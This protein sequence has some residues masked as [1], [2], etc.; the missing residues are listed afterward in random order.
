MAEEAYNSKG[1]PKKPNDDSINFQ[2]LLFLCAKNWYWFLISLLIALSL[3][4]MYIMI[5]QPVYTRQASLLIRE[6]DKN[7][8]ISKEFSQFS[9]MGV[10][11]SRTNLHNEMITLKS[12]TYMIDVV[13]KLHLDVNYDIDGAFHKEVLYGNN[14]P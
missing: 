13:K 6:D 2:D 1:Y 8:A 10:S 3:G 9:A 7:Q 5:T 12:P 14:L 4:V 11:K